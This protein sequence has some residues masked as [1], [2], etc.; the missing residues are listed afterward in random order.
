MKKIFLFLPF[1]LIGLSCS[2]ID[3]VFVPIEQD[4]EK[5]TTRGVQNGIYHSVGVSYDITDEYLHIDAT[6]FPVV[7]IGA[8][9]SLSGYPNSY[10]PN[11]A[12]EG[13]I[14]MYAGATAKDFLEDINIKTKA[15]RNANFG[16]IASASLR[17]ESDMNTKNTY[18][19]KYSY[20]R[21]DVIKRI[22]RVYLN[23]TPEMLRPYVYPEFIRDLNIY[24]PDEFVRRYGTHV[25]LDITI[26]GKLQFNYR[27]EIIEES[28]STQKKL[29]VESGA[30]VGIKRFGADIK[31]EIDISTLTQNSNKNAKWDLRVRYIGGAQSGY[32]AS[33]NSEGYISSSF[34]I[35][36]WESSVT[37]I[38]A[39]I[40]EINWEHTY[41]I[42]DFI[43]DPVKRVAIEAAIKRY[44]KQDE[45]KIVEVKPLYRMYD[46]K[47]C[48]TYY[49][50]SLDEFNF[51]RSRHNWKPNYGR[52]NSHILGY[53]FATQQPGTVPIYRMYSAGLNNTFYSSSLSE[54]NH[55]LRMGY[56]WDA[57]IVGSYIVGYIYS[58]KREGTEAIQRLFDNARKVQDTMLSVNPSEAQWYL[59]NY[60]STVKDYGTTNYILG[61][62]LLP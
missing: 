24:S 25:L 55:Y 48:N 7:D 5:P 54:A 37:E 45:V 14:L 32:S 2:N 9:L 43:A 23:A 8:Y 21:A 30:K 28:S 62:L 61:Y 31:N 41:P 56:G 46:E 13:D 4:Q 18:S 11:T 6:K 58:T 17:F 53:V 15:N 59:A 3:D 26:G 47:G 44:V 10:I 51:Y 19:T 40:L 34:N 39:A 33:F 12:S 52:T 38:N 57:G 36:A 1:L 50:S 16:E 35:S 49:T 27:S 42:S 20:A 29:V 22:K 60:K